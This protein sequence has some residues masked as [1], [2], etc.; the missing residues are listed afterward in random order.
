MLD[1]VRLGS[2]IRASDYTLRAGWTPA[3]RSIEAE[4]LRPNPAPMCNG[5]LA[6]TMAAKGMPGSRE[7]TGGEES[8]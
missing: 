5:P 3:L 2:G 6:A 4:G 7:G 8:E 1:Q